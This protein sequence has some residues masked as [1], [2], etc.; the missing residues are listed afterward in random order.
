MSAKSNPRPYPKPDKPRPVGG[1][2][3]T[4]MDYAAIIVDA[5]RQM[6][7]PTRAYVVAIATSLQ[8]SKLLNLANWS[9]PESLN[10]A[11]DGVGGDHDSV[12]LFQQRPSSGW[13]MVEE[14]MDPASSARKFYQALVNVVG[15]QGMTVAAAAQA[16][17]VSAFPDAYA[18]RE[19]L[20]TLI[21]DALVS[22][23]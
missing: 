7:L 4:Q 15:W 2:T 18:Q 22:Q 23:A 3:Q 20:A 1:L 21:V 6:Q 8:E 19:A 11:H 17:Q 9:V 16:V 13:G 12:G 5:G 10:W 14:L